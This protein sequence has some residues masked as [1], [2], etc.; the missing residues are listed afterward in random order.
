MT[1]LGEHLHALGLKF[2]LYTVWGSGTCASTKSR[3]FHGSWGHEAQD[4]KTF[5][6][7]GV[8][9]VGTFLIC[10][11]ASNIHCCARADGTVSRFRTTSKKTLAAAQTT[12]HFGSAMH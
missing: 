9:G 2:G 10:A 8:V 1:A 3:P 4:A 6:R 12:A 7:W 11:R 5:A